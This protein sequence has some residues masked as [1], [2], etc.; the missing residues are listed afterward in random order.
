MKEMLNLS[1]LSNAEL[2]KELRTAEH[3]LFAIA[4][5]LRQGKEKR[6]HML[7]QLRRKIARLKTLLSAAATT[8]TT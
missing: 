6:T 8:P 4:F 5:Q 3:E 2:Q 7:K 1:Q